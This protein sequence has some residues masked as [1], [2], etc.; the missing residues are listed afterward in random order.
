[1]Q[2]GLNA[3]LAGLVSSPTGVRNLADLVAFND[4]HKDLEEPAGHEDQTS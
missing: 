3:W 2:R 1:M 4:G